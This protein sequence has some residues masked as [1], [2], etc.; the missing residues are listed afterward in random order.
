MTCVRIH[1]VEG[2]FHDKISVDI[3]WI[4]IC[5]VPIQLSKANWDFLLFL[6]LKKVKIN[7][8]SSWNVPHSIRHVTY[9]PYKFGIEYF[10]IWI[11]HER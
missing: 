11:L 8:A 6:S 2:I 4:L 3:Y 9:S 10:D 7:Y 5:S 1:C